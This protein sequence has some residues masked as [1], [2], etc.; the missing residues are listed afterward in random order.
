MSC[1]IPLSLRCCQRVSSRDSTRVDLQYLI[2]SVE[3]HHSSGLCYSSFNVNSAFDSSMMDKVW[4]HPVLCEQCHLWSRALNSFSPMSRSAR[5]YRWLLL[6]CWLSVLFCSKL[7]QEVSLGS[8]ICPWCCLLLLQS[9][10]CD[11]T[12]ANTMSCA[13]PLA[14]CCTLLLADLLVWSVLS[15]SW[16]LCSARESCSVLMLWSKARLSSPGLKP[17]QGNVE[18]QL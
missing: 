13:H 9:G 5:P 6:C 17:G 4:W 10:C 8:H 14:V 7:V 12:P 1:W 3:T 16:S 18:D 2:R 11:W 15:L